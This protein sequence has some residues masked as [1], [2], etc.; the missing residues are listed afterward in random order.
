VSSTAIS[1]PFRSECFAWSK[2]AVSEDVDLLA[3]IQY[4]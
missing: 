2:I 4:A 1:S 3:K